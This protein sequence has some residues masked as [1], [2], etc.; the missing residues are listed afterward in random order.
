MSI[1]G[2]QADLRAINVPLRE[3]IAQA[4]GF[5]F[6][7]DSPIFQ[8][9]TRLTGGDRRLL[10]TRFDI[11]AK[12]PDGI[13]GR[14]H[15]PAMLRTLLGERFGLRLHQES[16]PTP[17]YEL[18]LLRQGTFGPGFRPSRFDCVDYMSRGGAASAPD[19]PRN[20]DGD[21][22]CWPSASGRATNGSVTII[23]AGRLDQLVIALQPHVDRPIVDA[24]GLTGTFEWNV[25]FAGKSAPADAS[26]VSVFTAVEEQLGLKLVPVVGK[27]PDVFV[28][29]ALHL[30]APD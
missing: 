19:A 24:T 3:L 11:I 21:S 15:I 28:I 9:E 14:R 1:D 16:K 26:T 5:G 30:P 22:W 2:G 20:A 7:F 13:T 17:V 23:R 25:T 4:Y 6:A 18:R 29:D 12:F 10:D 8:N 27:A